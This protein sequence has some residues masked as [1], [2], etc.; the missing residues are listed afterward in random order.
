MN[1]RTDSREVL[2][3]KNYN[4]RVYIVCEGRRLRSEALRVGSLCKQRVHK[5][6][7]EGT[8]RVHKGYTEGT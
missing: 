2:V 4:A 1:S 6:Y 5:G 3:R 7:T 8:Q